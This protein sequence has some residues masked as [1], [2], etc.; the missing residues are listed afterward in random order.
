MRYFRKTNGI[1]NEIK[2]LDYNGVLSSDGT[3]LFGS[4]IVDINTGLVQELPEG[5][6]FVDRTNDDLLLIKKVD[7]ETEK[8]N[9][10][11]YNHITGENSKIF[12]Y[13]VTQFTKPKFYSKQNVFMAIPYDGLVV[14][15]YFAIEKPQVKYA[16]SFDGM[17]N[18]YTYTGGRWKLISKS[19][20]PSIKEMQTY[21]MTE[22]EINS[23]PLDAYNKLYEEGNSVLTVDFAIY[24]NSPFNNQSPTVESIMISTQNDDDTN[25]FYG[26][27]MQKYEK[28]EYRTVSSVFP[29]ENFT[30][31]AECYYL[32][33]IGNEWLYTYK[34]NKLVKTVES[35]D[36]LLSDIE[37]SWITFK[38][39]GMTSKELRSVPSDVINNLFV[40]DNYA[41]SEFGIIYVVKTDS[42]EIDKFTVDFKLKSESNFITEDDIVIE[43]AMSSG[44]VIVV[45]SN[46]FSKAEIENLLSWIEGRQNGVGTI[47]YRIINSKKQHFINYYMINS[48]NVYNGAEYRE[49]HSQTQ[50][51]AE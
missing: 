29:I 36:E 2:T 16:L 47:F 25:G 21:G 10:Y 9:Y 41:N 11:L 40:N 23:I 24:M 35:A 8:C 19:N 20:T 22:E 30:S 45:D 51:I 27:H 32:L 17:N 7:S 38:Q 28:S 37:S 1:W 50:E 34:D 4:K 49:S 39:Y 6:S 3:T 5:F 48:I 44:E 46:E 42:D 31:N 14:R 43:I 13:E 26:I 18:W 15:R 12:E 33:Y